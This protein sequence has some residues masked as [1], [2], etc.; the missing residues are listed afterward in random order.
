M[1]GINEWIYDRLLLDENEVTTIQG[2]GPKR[3][4][5]IKFAQAHTLTALLDRTKG[6]AT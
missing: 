3:Q 4:V 5:C 1:F 2:D 6:T